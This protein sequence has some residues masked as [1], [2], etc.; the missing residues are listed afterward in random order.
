MYEKKQER[1]QKSDERGRVKN[2]SFEEDS[3]GGEADEHNEGI[4][5][6]LQHNKWG[7]KSNKTNLWNGLQFS[8]TKHKPARSLQTC[9]NSCSLILNVF[10]FYCLLFWELLTYCQR[11]STSS[12]RFFKLKAVKGKTFNPVSEL[13][14]S[15]LLWPPGQEVVNFTDSDLMIKTKQNSKVEVNGNNYLLKTAVLKKTH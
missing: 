6:S 3:G 4:K 7:Q 5:V 11:N 12:C 2:G 9:F 1:E 8:G 10:S 14:E 13:L 15:F